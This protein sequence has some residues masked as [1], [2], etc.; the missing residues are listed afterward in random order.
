[1]YLIINVCFHT[2]LYVMLT[3]SY[4]FIQYCIYGNYLNILVRYITIVR[5]RTRYSNNTVQ[6]LQFDTVIKSIFEQYKKKAK[7]KWQNDK[8]TILVQ[9]LLSHEGFPKVFS[10]RGCC[11]SYLSW[12][13][14]FWSA[15]KMNPPPPLPENPSLSPSLVA[16]L[17]SSAP[18]IDNSTAKDNNEGNSHCYHRY[19]CFY[20]YK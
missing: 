16:A 7:A 4:F 13:C 18:S 14:S 5:C 1:M 2:V 11:M 20:G 10:P 8:M 9:V 15:L 6:T 12:L 19:C 17:D 3:V